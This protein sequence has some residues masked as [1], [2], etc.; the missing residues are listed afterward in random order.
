MSLLI[1]RK[2]GDIKLFAKNKTEEI[3]PN[4]N[5]SFDL[6]VITGI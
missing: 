3:T 2:M 6:V 5:F 1:S 4:R